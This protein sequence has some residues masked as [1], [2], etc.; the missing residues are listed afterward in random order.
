M[1]IA[2]QFVIELRF[3]VIEWKELRCFAD[4]V[5]GVWV[6]VDDAQKCMPEKDVPCDHACENCP[7]DID[8]CADG[9]HDCAVGETCINH[10]GVAPGRIADRASF[11]VILKGD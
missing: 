6:Y 8:E 1:Y 4:I 11:Q 3:L 7:K 10:F 9:S 5:N 2:P